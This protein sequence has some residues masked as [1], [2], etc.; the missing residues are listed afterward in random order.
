M[1]PHELEYRRLKE[2]A[3]DAARYPEKRDEVL[4]EIARHVISE[5]RAFG[6]SDGALCAWTNISGFSSFKNDLKPLVASARV[7]SLLQRM[8]ALAKAS[9][10]V[11]GKAKMAAVEG[12]AK[13]YS[14]MMTRA[15]ESEAWKA[16]QAY[17]EAYGAKKKPSNEVLFYDAPINT[18][19]PKNRPWV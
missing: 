2:R 4:R 14:E 13:V 1:H 19:T 3:N 8:W 18:N 12:S 17:R 6:F 16:T 15:L 7:Q 11:H 9:G 5:L 10:V